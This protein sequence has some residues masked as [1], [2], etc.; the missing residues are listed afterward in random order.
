M[1]NDRRKRDLDPIEDSLLH[2][3]EQ[4]LRGNEQRSQCNVMNQLADSIQ[5][6]FKQR[7]RDGDLTLPYPDE[8]LM[9]TMQLLE[10]DEVYAQQF[11]PWVSAIHKVL[12]AR[13]A[14]RYG[15]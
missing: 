3:C 9:P 2:C 6:L 14:S 8:E 12:K 11:L 13:M 10:R 1:P 4:Y 7:K 15:T 5:Q